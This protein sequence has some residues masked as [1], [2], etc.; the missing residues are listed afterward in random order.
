MRLN[1]FIASTGHCSRRKADAL[2]E[3][4]HVHVNGKPVELGT[5]IDPQKDTITIDGKPL[6][7]PTE[8]TLVMLHKPADYVCTKY[9][10]NVEQTIYELLPEKYHHLNPV[11]RLDKETEGLLLL[12]DDGDLLYKMTHP[13]HGGKKVYDVKLK[14]AP[15]PGQLSRLEEGIDIKEEKGT[16]HTQPCTIT[17]RNAPNRFQITITEGRKRQ[18]R[19][20]FKAIGCP[21][22]YLKRLKMGP[23]RL[24]DLPKGEWKIITT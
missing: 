24:G 12:T 10:P 1:K 22:V 7:A 17:H 15:P 14:N 8:S 13:K 23:Y 5:P 11:G 18:I 20:M 21:V 4:G 16:Y 2:I 6:Q 3:E 19:K 9:D